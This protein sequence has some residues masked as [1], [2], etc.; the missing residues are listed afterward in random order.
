[1]INFQTPV[2]LWKVNKHEP[3]QNFRRNKDN[4]N[5]KKIMIKP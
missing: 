5:K 3:D 1:M 2:D 4:N